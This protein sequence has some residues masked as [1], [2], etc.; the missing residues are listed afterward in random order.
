MFDADILTRAF[1][2]V[3]LAELFPDFVHPETGQTLAEIAAGFDLQR[4]G[5]TLREECDLAA[6]I[7]P[8]L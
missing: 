7:Q 5:M 2:A 3:P 4:L 6:L 8:Q 1:V